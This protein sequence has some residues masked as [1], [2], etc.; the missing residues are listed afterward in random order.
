MKFIF[1]LFLL[2][3]C[4]NLYSYIDFRF[5][6]QLSKNQHLGSYY[7]NS[8]KSTSYNLI[9]GKKLAKDTQYAAFIG[10][11]IMPQHIKINKF[12]Y[13]DIHNILS[14]GFA[15]SCKIGSNKVVNV[16]LKIKTGFINSWKVGSVF[17]NY[18]YKSSDTLLHSG[19]NLN[20]GV[21][22]EVG[23]EY[24]LLKQRR[25]GSCLLLNYTL[26]L[27]NF[28]YISYGFRNST[29]F[30]GNLKYITIGLTFRQYLSN[31]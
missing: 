4:S 19:A 7:L 12:D 16:F 23:A 1:I 3:K 9:I 26:G 8:I 29:E 17:T 22:A 15:K 21:G 6:Y 27:R 30:T 18:Y 11:G 2:I 28:K 13:Y 31:L 20:Y 24:N 5:N 10:L 25:L 14:F